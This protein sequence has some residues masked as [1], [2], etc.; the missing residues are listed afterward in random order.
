MKIRDD[1]IDQL[2]GLQYKNQELQ[3]LKT[4]KEDEINKMH[5]EK[6][7]LIENIEQSKKRMLDMDEE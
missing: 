3:D 5:Q 1:Q 7:K 4:A 2:T 6:Q